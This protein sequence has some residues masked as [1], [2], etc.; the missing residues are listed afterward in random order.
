MP[1]DRKLFDSLGESGARHRKR[2]G[3]VREALS[4]GRV[5]AL[6]PP[7]ERKPARGSSS[8]TTQLPTLGV[9][10]PIS[11]NVRDVAL[12]VMNSPGG[13]VTG[14]GERGRSVLSGAYASWR[15]RRQ[16]LPQGRAAIAVPPANRETSQTP[17]VVWDEVADP[18]SDLEALYRAFHSGL[19]RGAAAGMPVDDRVFSSEA[20]GR[21]RGLL[22]SLLTPV[23]REQY[24]RGF[25]EVRGQ[26][27]ALVYRIDT[28]HLTY[29]VRVGGG[30][31]GLV[32][33][34]AMPSGMMPREDKLLGQMMGLKCDERNFLRAAN[35]APRPGPEA[36]A[37]A[38]ALH[39]FAAGG[40]FR[41]P[42][43]ASL[44]EV[45]LRIGQSHVA[46]QV[47]QLR[48]RSTR[49]TFIYAGSFEQ[50][51]QYLRARGL[52]QR[53][54]PYLSPSR[55]TWGLYGF[56]L[57]R[58]GTWYARSDRDAVEELIAAGYFGEVID[59]R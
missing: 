20:R 33:L 31:D 3:N 42:A 48:A 21:A 8:A 57:I 19:I 22:L 9:D 1:R 17:V 4:R 32:K 12:I 18:R 37:L 41:M 16:L 50:Y 13:E 7:P 54:Y 14:Q 43:S 15:A 24:E 25:I 36:F 45:S 10:T 27:T 56:P 35:M 34:C 38:R 58:V 47:G 5:P 29:N 28:S 2:M 40:D 44:P 52:S 39:Q 11:P 46:V 23:Q 59:E 53:E 26:L 51:R 55:S 30:T 6:N 49:R